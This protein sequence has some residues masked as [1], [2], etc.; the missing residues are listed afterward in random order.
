MKL[1]KILF[2]FFL[3]SYLN[4]SA[5]VGVNTTTPNAQLDIVS[6]NQATPSNT[7]GIL[8]PRINVFP[9][10]NPTASQQ[11]MMVYLTTTSGSNQPGFY[12]WDN[13]S[14]SWKGI[15]STGWS[16]T[17]NSGTSTLTTVS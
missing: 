10:T 9:A 3:I 17:G 2:F 12:Y 15:G 13:T 7:D 16:L 1:K 11:S 5:Q 6:S 14:T 4:S 8:I